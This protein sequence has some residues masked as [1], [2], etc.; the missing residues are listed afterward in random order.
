MV[1]DDAHD[2]LP[3]IVMFFLGPDGELLNCHRK[4]IPTN[5]ERTIWGQGDASGLRVVDTPAGRIGALPCWEA[6]MPLARMT[7]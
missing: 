5:H 3:E 1:D 4:L 6:L 7:R 2:A